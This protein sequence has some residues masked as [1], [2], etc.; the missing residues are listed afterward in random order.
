MGSS[1]YVHY[2]L[3]NHLGEKRSKVNA[4]EFQSFLIDLSK[5][6]AAQNSLII[7]DD[8]DIHNTEILTE[9]YKTIKSN[10]GIDVLFLPPYSPFLNPIEHSIN[11]L[12]TKLS[13][14]ELNNRGELFVAMKE[15]IPLI[16]TPTNTVKW[17][18]QCQKYNLQCEMG[19]PFTGTILSPDIL[20]PNQNKITVID[21]M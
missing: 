8:R 5:Q 6:L 17:H 10:Y 21:Q 2:E 9:T 19:L 4:N 3:I 16:I 14:M 13:E 20:D 12:K 18:N 15:Q 7:L 1:G 11:E